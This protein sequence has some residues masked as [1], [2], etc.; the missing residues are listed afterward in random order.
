MKSTYEKI[1]KPTAKATIVIKD[2]KT[3]NRK[4][5]H[6]GRNNENI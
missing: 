4:E 3:Y 2:K 1:R 5:K 6:K